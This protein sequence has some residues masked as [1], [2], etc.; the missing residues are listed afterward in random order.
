MF[1]ANA[2]L[3]TRVY[4][5][6]I[7]TVETPQNFESHSDEEGGERFRQISEQAVKDAAW[8]LKKVC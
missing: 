8:L 7:S 1:S 3:V 2:A 5:R 4:E 6:N